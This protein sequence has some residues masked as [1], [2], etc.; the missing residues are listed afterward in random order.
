MLCLSWYTPFNL[1]DNFSQKTSHTLYNKCNVRPDF[2]NYV[3]LE[4]ACTYCIWIQVLI[5]HNHVLSDFHTWG[6]SPLFLSTLSSRI[7]FT[8]LK[9]DWVGAF[10]NKR[11]WNALRMH[12]TD[13]ITKRKPDS[14]SWSIDNLHLNCWVSSFLK[15]LQQED[16]HSILASS[17]TPRG[18]YV[19]RDAL[20]QLMALW[21]VN[22]HQIST[23]W[24]K[25]TTCK[26]FF[27]FFN[28]TKQRYISKT[29]IWLRKISTWFWCDTKTAKVCYI[30]NFFLSI[31]PC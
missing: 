11:C 26:S 6:I 25:K 13:E 10:C 28:W 7:P 24:I 2:S 15:F 17:E 30:S 22:L 12:Q 5:F 1:L 31:T 27:F 21:K 4:Y 18:T 23:V 19:Q 16:Q 20:M 8:T 29:K 14:V 3:F 9:S